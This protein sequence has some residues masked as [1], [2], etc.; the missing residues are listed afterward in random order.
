MLS[1][2][3]DRMTI[4]CKRYLIVADCMKHALSGGPGHLA[5]ISVLL[6]TVLV[7]QMVFD[8]E[9]LGL[10]VPQRVFDSAMVVLDAHLMLSYVVEVVHGFSSLLVGGFVM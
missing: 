8:L 9:E 3:A 10:G 1:S 6:I 7:L 5:E 4:D 2:N